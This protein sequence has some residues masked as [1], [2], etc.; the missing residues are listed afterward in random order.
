[1]VTVMGKP[2]PGSTTLT[3][4][5]PLERSDKVILP[6]SDVDLIELL[7]IIRKAGINVPGSVTSDQ[8]ENM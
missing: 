8:P 4:I 7:P 1:M 3:L 6:P 2:S 5:F